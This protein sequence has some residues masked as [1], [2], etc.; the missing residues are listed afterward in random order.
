MFYHNPYVNPLE[1][2]RISS[3][4]YCKLPGST[5]HCLIHK[6]L[7]NPYCWWFRNPVNSPVEVEVG[8]LSHY[9]QGFSTIPRWL[10]GISEP[11]TAYFSQIPRHF[12]ASQLFFPT[13]RVHVVVIHKALVFHGQ[14]RQLFT[15]HYL[16][17]EKKRCFSMKSWL[18]NRDP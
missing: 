16:S 1:L 6:P 5:G 12:T 14:F 4:I 7:I 9:L 8:S 18:I 17:Q 15:E 2:G 13:P 11:S 3:L 10:F